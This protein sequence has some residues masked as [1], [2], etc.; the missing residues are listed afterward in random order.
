MKFIRTIKKSDPN[1]LDKEIT[2]KLLLDKEIYVDMFVVKYLKHNKSY[3]KD[4]L[5]TKI[6]EKYKDKLVIENEF[7]EKRINKM[8]DQEYI[9]LEDNIL[10]YIS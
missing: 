9:K 1:T 7:Y 3:N 5:F 6:G 8:I 4:D 10:E 2:Q